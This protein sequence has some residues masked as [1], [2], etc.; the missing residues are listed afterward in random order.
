M[1][2]VIVNGEIIR[3]TEA[4]LTS[5]FWN[6]PQFFH[7]K[8][9]YGFGGIPLFFEN[10]QLIHQQINLFGAEIPSLFNHQRELF[11]IT[12][13]MLNKNKFFRSG[14]INIQLFI[15]ERK[16]DFVITSM[17]FPEFEFPINEQGLLVHF[18]E[19]KKD[20]GN[21]YN[22]FALYNQL[23]WETEKTKNEE[24]PF[25]NSIFLNE[26]EMVCDTDS[27]NIFMIKN[28]SVITPALE[29]GC[30][31]DILRDFIL[32]ISNELNFKITE[33]ANLKKDDVYNMNE[34]FLAGENNGFQWVMGIEGKRFVRQKSVL[35]HQKLNEFL[36]NKVH[37]L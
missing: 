21:I 32:S 30:Y 27:A 16:V 31:N 8:I 36:K 25:Q 3:K 33:A 11:R 24:T 22:R 9:W 20:S 10:I 37:Q 2:Y 17:S 4:N 19:I 7:H 5:F 13:R 35:I 15:Q 18:S 23:I 12:K 26:N 29:T 28:N 1:D 6:E 34:I 14:Q